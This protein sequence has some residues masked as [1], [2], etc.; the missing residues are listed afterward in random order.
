MK[1]INRLILVLL[2][3]LLFT[4]AVWAD[5]DDKERRD[6][7]Q[8]SDFRM[9]MTQRHEMMVGMMKMTRETMEILKNLNHKPS[10]AEKEK[11]AMMIEDLD[12]MMARD[13]EMSNKMMHKWNK[14]DKW[15]KNNHH[16]DDRRMMDDHH[17]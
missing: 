12:R 16:M 9:V 7:D 5:K 11:L 6:D 14:D 1:N 13:K 2:T 17:M 15:D 10:A 4:T 3:S 8:W